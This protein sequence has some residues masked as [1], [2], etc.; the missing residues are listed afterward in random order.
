MDNLNNILIPFSMIY[1][2]EM[3]LIRLI[4]NKYLDPEEFEDGLFNQP[5]GINKYFLKQRPMKNPLGEYTVKEED[6]DYYYKEF[7]E[8]KYLEILEYS[9]TT[10]V[11]EWVKKMI[12]YSNL[13]ITIICNIDEEMNMINECF[14]NRVQVIIPDDYTDIEL[15]IYD[16]IFVKDIEDLL[17]YEK[18]MDG[19]NIYMANYMHN[20]TFGLEEPVPDVRITT[21]L[22]DKAEL[23]IIDMY[24]EDEYIVSVG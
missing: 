4:K 3:G 21:L 18:S 13:S 10:T 9:I 1:D 14:G 24:S 23:N 12:D 8:K 19:K 6:A 15:K 20:Y 11:Y 7:I 22:L 2:T 17:L 5:D 16:T